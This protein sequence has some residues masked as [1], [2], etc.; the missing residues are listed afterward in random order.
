[1]DEYETAT[2]VQGTC[3]YLDPEYLQTYHFTDKSDVYSFGV[4]LVELLKRR[5]PLQLLGPEDEKGLATTFI[6]FLNQGKLED[7]IDLEILEEADGETLREI[8]QLAGRCLCVKRTDRPTMKEVSMA[9]EILGSTHEHP[10]VPE[11][12]LPEEK[13][14]LNHDLPMKSPMFP[15]AAWKPIIIQSL[16]LKEVDKLIVIAKMIQKTHV[17]SDSLGPCWNGELRSITMCLFLHL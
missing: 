4:I 9:L 14:L 7:I 10:W 6:S 8:S 16:T 1:M 15:T 17:W 5:K 13:S 3:G 2:V 11:P 12:T